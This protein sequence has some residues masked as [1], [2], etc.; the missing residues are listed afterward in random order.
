MT[1]RIQ[2]LAGVNGAGKSSIGGAEMRA[3]GSNYYNPDEATRQLQ[4]KGASLDDANARAWALGR[5]LLERAIDRGLDFAFETTLGGSTI[6]RLLRE[7]S[8][9]G[10]EVFVWYVGLASADLHLARV[11]A[12][13]RRGGHDIPETL[14]RQRYERSRLNL[15]SLLPSLTQLRLYDN[16][17]EGDPAAGVT[18]RPRLVLHFDRGMIVGPADLSATP[19]WARPVVAAVLRLAR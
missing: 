4:E 3:A 16:S 15:I 18:P 9:R 19:E 12:R 13:V 17:A 2:V 10:I 5:T 1:P 11:R 8:E 6:A 14:I 7:A